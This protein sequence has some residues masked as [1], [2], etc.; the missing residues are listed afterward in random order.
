[1]SYGELPDKVIEKIFKS[2][3]VVGL[4]A[5]QPLGDKE[6]KEYCKNPREYRHNG[7]KYYGKLNKT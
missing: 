6:I 1:M 3:F 7:Q 4:K 5:V 2:E